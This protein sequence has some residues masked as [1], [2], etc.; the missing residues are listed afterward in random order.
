M[1]LPKIRDGPEVRLDSPL[2]ILEKRHPPP[3]A[4]GSSATKRPP[5]NTH[6]P[7]SWSSCASDTEA[8]PAL[9]LHTRTRSPNGL[10]GPPRRIRNRTG[11]HPPTTHAGLPATANSVQ[12]GRFGMFLPCSKNWHTLPFLFKQIQHNGVQFSDT[13]LDNLRTGKE[14]LFVIAQ[15]VYKDAGKEHRSRRCMFLQPPANTQW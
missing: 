4:S 1:K 13:L 11:R 10:T 7:E 2:P 3:S 15:L 12:E 9:P 5:R 8:G 6:R 14:I